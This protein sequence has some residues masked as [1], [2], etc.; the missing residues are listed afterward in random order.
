MPI[1]SPLNASTPS[2]IEPRS[3]FADNVEK[4]NPELQEV[5]LKQ[6]AQ[7]NPAVNLFLQLAIIPTPTVRPGHEKEN[8]MKR[9]ME[10]G[11]TLYA[12]AFKELGVPKKNIERDNYGSLIIHVPAS[13]GYE[14]K[15]SLMFMGHMDIVP[16]DLKDPTRAIHPRLI[17]HQTQNGL[18]EYIATDGTT[19]LGADDKAC[20]AAIYYVVKTLIEKNIPHPPFEIIVA[21]DEEEEG[22]SMVNL[23]ASKFDSKYVIVIDDDKAFKITFGCGSFVN[24]KIDIDGLKGGHSAEYKENQDSIIS[25]ADILKELHE[26]IG[27]RVIKYFS[28]FQEVPLISKNIYEYEIDKS[29]SNRIPTGGHLYLSLRSNEKELEDKEVIKIEQA[30][31]EIEDKYKNTEPNLK[32]KINI[33]REMPPWNGDPKSLIATSLIQSAN[34]IG[35][36]KVKIA[37]SHGATQVNNLAGKKNHRGEEFVPVIIGVESEDWHKTEEKVSWESII[38]TG[39]WLVRLVENYTKL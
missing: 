3:A 24:I 31:K 38:E 2:P 15:Q 8:E 5:K 30:V 1:I 28:D 17:M 25:A 37:P 29:A 10:E 21:P 23:D 36:E 16:A 18:K 14:N 13:P 7:N 35:Q 34:E 26:R 9:K 6:I 39:N 20:L 11:M 19:T 4:D 12:Q 27:N 32:I 22:S 33:H